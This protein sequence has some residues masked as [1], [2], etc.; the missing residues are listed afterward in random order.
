MSKNFTVEIE[1]NEWIRARRFYSC[2]LDFNKN[3]L[4][5]VKEYNDSLVDKLKA[6]KVEDFTIEHFRYTIGQES[7]IS[8]EEGDLLDEDN[9]RYVSYGFNLEQSLSNFIT[10][11]INDMV[12][13]CDYDEEW[14][15]CDGWEDTVEINE[16]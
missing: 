1:R 10:D 16:D 15:D 4:P 6:F 5:L 13:D 11:A 8:L 14:L 3:I 12:W 7:N 9:E 2:Q